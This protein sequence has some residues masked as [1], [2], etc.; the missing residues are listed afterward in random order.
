M[1]NLRSPTSWR[2][3]FVK[4]KKQKNL[5][6]LLKKVKFIRKNIN[7]YPEQKMIFNAFLLTPLLGVKVVIL[8]Q[9]PYCR[10][11]QAHGLSFSVLRGIRLPPSLKNIFQELKNNFSIFNTQK[12][13][14]CL[15]SWAEQGVFLLNSI[16]TVS[17]GLPGSHRGIGWEIFTDEVIQLIS[18]VCSGV[19]FLL[20][21]SFSRSK[22]Y[23]IDQKKHFILQA[24]HPSPR[25]CYRSFFGCRHFL[26]TNILLKRQNKSPINWFKNMKY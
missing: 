9:D 25:S 17:E 4:K 13:H 12:M 23:L 1:T 21:G 2:N 7:V 24:S 14:G 3:F 6:Q 15:E 11:G 10:F 8:G 16:L 5:M 22:Q 18:D 19:V 26:K 20:W